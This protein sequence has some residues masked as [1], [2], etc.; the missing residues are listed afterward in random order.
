M[1][2]AFCMAEKAHRGQ[3]R[4]SG[5]PYFTH[6]VEVAEI[7]ADMHLDE[8][9]IITALL[10][11]VVEDT[12]V[13]LNQ[14]KREFGAEIARLVDGVTKL[15]RLEM[16]SD[17]K[18][19][20][21]FRKLL[22]AMSEDIR[23]L[24]VKLADRT[25]NMRTIDYIPDAA[26]RE[27]IA[28]ETLHIFA[29]LAERVGVSHFQHELEDRAFTVINPEMRKTILNR[30]DDVV[31]K[32]EKTVER[33]CEELT[34]TLKKAG[35][36]VKV[37]GRQKTPYSIWRK[38]QRQKV[39][40]EELSDIMA[41]RVIVGSEEECYR[42]LGILH[43]H[44]PMVMGRFKDYISTP[45]RNRYRSL[46]TGVI[47]PLKKKIEIQIRSH[48]MHEIA[49][50][51]V[52][53]HWHYKES[54]KKIHREEVSTM[55]WLNDLVNILE[56]AGSSDEFLEHTQME[57]YSDQVFC[58][59]PKGALINLP[60]GATAIDFAYAVHS[61]IGNHC[62]GTRING[63]TRQLATVLN[64]G[65]QVEIITDQS[66]KPSPE[67]ENCTVTGKAKSAIGRFTRIEKQREFSRL[68]EALVRKTFRQAKRKLENRHLPPCLTHFNL[69][70]E[71][72]LFARVGEDRIKPEEIY[73]IVFPEARRPKARKLGA[74]TRKPSLNIKGLI[75]GMAV[76]HGSCCHPLP[77]DRIV[78]IVTTGKGITVHRVDCQNLEK[79]SAMPELWLDIEW[80]RDTPGS[81][82]ARLEVVLSNE[83]GSLASVATL[84]SRFE[85]NI[86]NIQLV[87]R[88]V[89]FFTFIFDVEV[90]SVRHLTAI[91]AA[92]RADPFVESVERAKT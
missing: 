6:P 81:V 48:E 42:A 82:A 80:E 8:A 14:I 34:K 53:A 33:I 77:G 87:N 52:A 1:E 90:G 60:K 7:L 10:H 72:E 75:P 4:S 25:H 64:N 21:N 31:S 36:K 71:E 86:T 76:H 43:L 74:K 44:Y 45:K 88:S 5:D 49:E 62:V 28:R 55:K 24:L 38:M 65:D 89:D 57:M 18:Q 40:M 85:G 37:E 69:N 39:E 27:R 50:H 16:Q 23:V 73:Q 32:S 46:H 59:T 30:L 67:W 2:S 3:L 51:G 11:D 68:G 17:N 63:R 41:F 83:H 12:D 47:G 26:K 58:F 92:M 9:T 66:A 54:G 13:T 29:P 56:H 19:A 79:F 61:D 84:I 22:L 70:S 91:V 35:L 78:G 20:E 15:T